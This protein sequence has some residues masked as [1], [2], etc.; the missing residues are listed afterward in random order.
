MIHIKDISKTY[1]SGKHNELV[2]IKNVTLQIENGEML[3]IMGRSGAGKST[4]LHILACI[5]KPDRGTY[6]L[7]NTD[8]TNLS[9]YKI[10]LMR[11]RNIG[12]VLQNFALIPSETAL[13]NVSTPL[14]FS[15]IPFFQ[16]K[17]K[18]LDALE[19]IKMSSYKNQRVSTLSGGEKQRIAI[20]RAMVNNPKIILAD[21]PTGS[22]DTKTSD[23]IMGIFK[24]LNRNGTTI[25]IVTHDLKIAESC[26]RIIRIED[27]VIL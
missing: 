14:Y 19:T 16:I 13:S 3:A 20:A 6:E 9:E 25:V 7:E 8:I 26:N 22:L 1:N 15:Q 4:L 18:A 5:D 10:A 2:V 12:I 27:G 24:M 21:E 11:N 17:K 23:E